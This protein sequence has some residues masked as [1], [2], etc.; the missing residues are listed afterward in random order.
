[1]AKTHSVRLTRG[2]QSDL[3]DIAAYLEREASPAIARGFLDDVL[4]L[5]ESLET[6]P[7]RG[8]IPPELQAVG[9]QEFRQ[10][11]MRPY[12]IVYRVEGGTVFIML[13]ADGRRDMQ[14][15]LERRLFRE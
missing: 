4:E 13:V 14:A 7:A 10:L 2:A 15:L 9:I 8:S 12:R 1:M 6:L 11:I 5:V 3:A